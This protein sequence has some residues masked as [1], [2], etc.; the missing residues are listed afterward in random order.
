MSDTSTSE[1]KAEEAEAPGDCEH[2]V[3]IFA[4]LK[5]YLD[6]VESDVLMPA[7]VSYL[8]LDGR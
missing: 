1:V 6:I 3:L 7:G 5:S 4:Q 8:R 2:R